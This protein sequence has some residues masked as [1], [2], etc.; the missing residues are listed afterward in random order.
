MRGYYPRY[1]PASCRQLLKEQ[2]ANNPRLLHEGI[3][4]L[5][6]QLLVL[7]FSVSACGRILVFYCKLLTNRINYT[8]L[9]YKQDNKLASE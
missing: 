8:E 3:R 5:Y 4:K 9:V 2:L 6:S 1:S 7:Q